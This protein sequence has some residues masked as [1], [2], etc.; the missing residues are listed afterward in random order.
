[1]I[2]VKKIGK[3]ESFYLID[4]NSS[5]DPFVS[6]KSFQ[7]LL[8]FSSHFLCLLDKC[9]LITL[10]NLDT[11]TSDRLRVWK[12]VPLHWLCWD[13]P[14]SSECT[15][16]QLSRAVSKSPNLPHRH[17]HVFCEKVP[18]ELYNYYQSILNLNLLTLLPFHYNQKV[19][20]WSSKSTRIPKQGF[21]VI[22]ISLL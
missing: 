3:Y 10:V 12:S 4:N 1:M 7:S 21:I 5:D 20:F 13:E 15:C 2:I 11:K 14:P 18:R 6:H 8:H 16:F 17:F 9:T 22:Q 19:I